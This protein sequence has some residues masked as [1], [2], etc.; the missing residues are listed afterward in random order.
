MRKKIS[1]V[2]NL[3]VRNLKRVSK[4]FHFSKPFLGFVEYLFFSVFYFIKLTCV[5]MTRSLF[6]SSRVRNV[7]HRTGQD[8]GTTTR[9]EIIMSNTER[10]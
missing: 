5:K 1:I 3:F 7:L 8:R 2:R 10:F 6:S 4:W 9:E